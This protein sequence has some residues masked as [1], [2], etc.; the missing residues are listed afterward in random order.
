MFLKLSKSSQERICI[1]VKR[2]WYMRFPVNLVEFSRTSVLQN[3]CQRILETKQLK[4]KILINIFAVGMRAQ[5]FTSKELNHRQCLVKFVNFAQLQFYRRLLITG[6]PLL[7]SSNIFD[8]SLALSAIYK[9]S[10]T[11]NSRNSYMH[12]IPIASSENS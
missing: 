1:E 5:G 10:H 4:T 7:I 9:F 2:V 3:I 8:V 6:R 12:V 11:R